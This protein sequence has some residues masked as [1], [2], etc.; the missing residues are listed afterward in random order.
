MTKLN[1]VTFIEYEWWLR[2]VAYEGKPQKLWLHVKKEVL[3]ILCDDEVDLINNAK[4]ER[5]EEII[6]HYMER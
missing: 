2:E 4:W 5:K 1:E 3:R 6:L